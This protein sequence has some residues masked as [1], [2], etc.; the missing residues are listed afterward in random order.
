M[1]LFRCLE[2]CLPASV[3][4]C[5]TNG[6]L[7]NYVPAHRAWPADA[8]GAEIER[9]LVATA[10]ANPAIHFFEH[11]LATDLLSEWRERFLS[12]LSAAAYYLGSSIL[13]TAIW[14]LLNRRRPLQPSRRG[15][16]SLT[17]ALLS[18]PPNR[19]AAEDVGG[20]RYCLGADV[21]DQQQMR[22]TR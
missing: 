15:Y 14:P 18:T 2:L 12:F 7:T 9:A 6:L 13:R 10:R 4:T 5:F 20:I 22:M 17:P 11:H 1:P 8:T 19:S 21:L 16:F 3:S